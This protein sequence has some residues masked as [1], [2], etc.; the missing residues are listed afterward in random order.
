[1]CGSVRKGVIEAFKQHMTVSKMTDETMKQQGKWPV[2][3]P[4]ACSTLHGDLT[5]PRSPSMKPPKLPSDN[6]LGRKDTAYRGEESGDSDSSSEGIQMHSFGGRLGG[7][8][9]L[10]GSQRL[11]SLPVENHMSTQD[12]LSAG[13]RQRNSCDIRLDMSP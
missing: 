7:S 8:L 4:E 2:T 12:L 6:G 13:E 9:G 5:I 3:V 1:M 11:R 10:R